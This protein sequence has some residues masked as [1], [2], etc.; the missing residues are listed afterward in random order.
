MLSNFD[1]TVLDTICRLR[2]GNEAYGPG[3]GYFGQPLKAVYRAMPEHEAID[4]LAAATR[5]TRG[6]LLSGTRHNP[7]LVWITP[8]G[9]QQWSEWDESRHRWLSHAEN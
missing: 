1:Q 2:A 9:W 7:A 3:D 4:V 6:G 8:R 5:L